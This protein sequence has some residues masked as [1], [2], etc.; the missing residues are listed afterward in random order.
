MLG[1]LERSFGI[2]GWRSTDTDDGCLREALGAMI[3]EMHNTLT[4]PAL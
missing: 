3:K 4:K 2:H 1:D